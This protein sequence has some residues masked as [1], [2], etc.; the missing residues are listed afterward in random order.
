MCTILEDFVD[1]LY[2]TSSGEGS[3]GFPITIT[4]R[5]EDTPT[6]QTIVLQSDTGLPLEQQEAYLGGNECDLTLGRP[7]PSMRQCN[8][9]ASSLASERPLQPSRL[10]LT[11]M[12]LRQRGS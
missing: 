8:G 4:P 5:S 12:R 2:T 6:P 11:I 1:E 9:K 10:S 3:S 7:T